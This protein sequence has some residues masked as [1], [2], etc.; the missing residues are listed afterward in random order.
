MGSRFAP[1][2]KGLSLYKANGG[3]GE[4]RRPEES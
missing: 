4:G 3:P 1:K 2:A